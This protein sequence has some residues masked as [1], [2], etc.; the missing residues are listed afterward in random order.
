MSVANGAVTASESQFYLDTIPPRV[1][2]T[3]PGEGVVLVNTPLTQ[4]RATLT[5]GPGGS[6][7]DLSRS[8]IQLIGPNGEVRGTLTSSSKEEGV[9]TLTADAVPTL[10]GRDDG[11]YTIRVIAFD[12]ASNQAEPYQTIFF[13]DT[14]QPGSPAASSGLITRAACEQ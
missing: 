12:K 2:K 1:L 11:R 3:E 6:G 4:I 13:Y 8:A 7:V 9:L 14:I 10:N 5:D